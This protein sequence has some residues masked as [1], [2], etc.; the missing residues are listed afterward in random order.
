MFIM[1]ASNTKMTPMIYL[2]DEIPE[3]IWN[4]SRPIKSTTLRK[5]TATYVA[6]DCMN[7]L[8]SFFFISLLSYVLD[9]I[10]VTRLLIYY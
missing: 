1:K 2:V 5:T 4:A 8:L 3:K 7:N 10:C 9:V 6:S